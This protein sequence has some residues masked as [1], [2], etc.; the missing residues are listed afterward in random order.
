MTASDPLSSVPDSQTIR[1]LIAESVSRTQLLRR[2]L[3]V[4]LTRERVGDRPAARAHQSE[5][6]HAH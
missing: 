5:V 6:A 2:L 1:R 4:A 3:R